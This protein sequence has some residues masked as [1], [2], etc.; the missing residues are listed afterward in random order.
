[1]V[2]RETESGKSIVRRQ[3]EIIWVI[4]LTQSTNDGWHGD[5]KVGLMISSQ[6]VIDLSRIWI[7][8]ISKVKLRLTNNL[9]KVI[10]TGFPSSLR[11]RA[12]L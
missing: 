12:I 9:L 11:I 3:F 10:I 7:L 1:L 2:Q 5:S 6:F 8:D 4:F